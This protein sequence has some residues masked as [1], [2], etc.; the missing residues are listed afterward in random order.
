MEALH[1]TWLTESSPLPLDEEKL[2][3]FS[4]LLDALCDTAGKMNVTA[5]K[6]RDAI[7]LRH[8]A[9]S[10]SLCAIPELK[11]AN[12]VADIGCGGGFPGLAIKIALP[13]LDMTMI[14]STEKKLRFVSDTAAKMGLKRV[15][16]V[17]DRAEALSALGKPMR[18][19]FDVV[20]A[21][22]VASLDILSELCLP[23]VKKGGVF[24]A[25]KG[26]RA[27][28]EVEAAKNGI[29]ELGGKVREIFP[30]GQHFSVPEDVAAAKELADFSEIAR[31]I[32]VIEKIKSTPPQYPRLYAK[33]K[34]KPL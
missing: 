4:V 24:L 27:A 22:A 14:D 16:T 10:L 33:I 9:D 1:R 21:R 11:K 20:T 17:A 5:L 13:H 7:V 34:S 19:S 3:A 29:R 2:Y 25:M 6:S 28:E 18:E 26:P 30:V 12:S 23:F 32:V 8:F 15:R 31:C